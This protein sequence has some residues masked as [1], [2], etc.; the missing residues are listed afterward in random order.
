MVTIEAMYARLRG[1]HDGVG[2]LLADLWRLDP[3]PPPAGPPPARL[4][5]QVA[6]VVGHLAVHWPQRAMFAEPS[7]AGPAT[8][9]QA[10]GAV[11]HSGGTPYTVRTTDGG[12]RC[13]CRWFARHGL[14]R[15]PCKHIL[16]VRL[17]RP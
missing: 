1:S 7:P 13:T 17:S 6:E 8:R 11:V 3:E 5:Q 16:A 4:R 15:G 9:S 2:I 12:E 14:G 10:E